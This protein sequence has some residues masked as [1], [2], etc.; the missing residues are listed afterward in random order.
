MVHGDGA[1]RKPGFFGR[2]KRRPNFH[3]VWGARDAAP[4][5]RPHAPGPHHPAGS[6]HLSQILA[7]RFAGDDELPTSASR[8]TSGPHAGVREGRQYLLPHD[9]LRGRRNRVREKL[10]S[11]DIQTRISEE[12]RLWFTVMGLAVSLDF[13]AD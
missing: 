12:S 2:L 13:L 1:G 4:A 11:K 5:L 10:S 7:L 6:A 9:T 8:R 3:S